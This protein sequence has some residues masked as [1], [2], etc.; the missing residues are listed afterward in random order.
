MFVDL[1]RFTEVAETL[2]PHWSRDLLADFHALIEREVVAL[3]GYVCSFMGDG[4]MIV[5][6]L[7][8]PKRDDASRA[9]LAIAQLD[10][11]IAAWLRAL[12]PVGRD[13][14][15]VRIGGHVGPVV[16]SRL[17]AAHHQHVTA[18]GDTVNVA[19]RL[20][21]VA[22]QHDSSVVVSEELYRASEFLELAGDTI[23]TK[24]AIEVNIRGRTEPLRVYLAFCRQRPGTI[25][26]GDPG[27][28]T[29]D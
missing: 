23:I 11:S 13:R 10:K 22:K 6:G 17:G 5:F 15:S 19:S 24:L 1:S 7:P 12:P 20:L 18:T 4:A 9:L 21:E 16:V 27:S 3:G 28:T 8:R 29:G 2:G 14:L 26:D 25:R